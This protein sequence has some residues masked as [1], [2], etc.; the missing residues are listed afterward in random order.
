MRGSPNPSRAARG[1]HEEGAAP[2]F[3]ETAPRFYRENV[4]GLHRLSRVRTA[5]S[6]DRHS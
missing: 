5:S 3:P 2:E 6:V 4:F 1:R